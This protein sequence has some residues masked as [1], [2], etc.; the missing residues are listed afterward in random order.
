MQVCVRACVC[1][2]VC[3]C[4]FVCVCMCA[5]VHVCVCVCVCVCVYVCELTFH[6]SN[7][8]GKFHGTMA[9]TTPMDDQP[10]ISVSMS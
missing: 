1:V 9:A 4:V 7:M 5:R 6:E 10:R 3:V 8:S 2:C